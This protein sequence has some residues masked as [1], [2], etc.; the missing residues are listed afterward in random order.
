MTGNTCSRPL[1]G[2]RRA[3]ALGRG[4]AGGA[5]HGGPAALDAAQLCGTRRARASPAMPSA[6]ARA[7]DRR[8]GGV[9]CPGSSMRATPSATTHPLLA[10]LAPAQSGAVGP[11][12]HGDALRLPADRRQCLSRAVEI[13]GAPREL[14]ALRPDRMRAVPRANGWP[15]AYRIFRQR[16]IGAAA[17][18][19]SGAASETVQS[20]RRSLRPVAARGG[21]AG[22]RHAQRRRRLEQGDARQCARPSG[23]LV[24]AA[25]DGAA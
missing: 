13:D 22:D 20:A 21:A 12:I 16:T 18:P 10:L 4:A 14:H 7:H 19:D 23:A 3:Q 15:E 5:A 8:G 1:R 2:W 11:R 6:I 24:Y 25:G 9:D 17:A